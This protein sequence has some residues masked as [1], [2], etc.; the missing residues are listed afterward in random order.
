MARRN[1]PGAASRRRAACG[2]VILIGLALGGFAFV[3][4]ACAEPAGT[5]PLVSRPPGPAAPSLPVRYS[6]APATLPEG[7]TRTAVERRSLRD[8]V[9]GAAGFLCGLSPI[10]DDRGAAAI[11]GYDPQGRFLGARLSF[12][13]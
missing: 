3:E 9:A 5:T 13:F 6:Y 10:A 4:A 8:G 2:R 12:S 11:T 7:I 1:S